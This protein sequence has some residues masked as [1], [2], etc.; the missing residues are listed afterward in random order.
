MFWLSGHRPLAEVSFS[1]TQNSECQGQ[2]SRGCT[3]NNPSPGL[4]RVSRF[5]EGWLYSERVIDTEEEEE[6]SRWGERAEGRKGGRSGRR[7]LLYL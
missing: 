6:G 5:S 4:L 7:V 3:R 2:G 1:W